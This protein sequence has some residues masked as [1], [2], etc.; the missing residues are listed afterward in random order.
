VLTTFRAR[1]LVPRTCATATASA[2]AA[3]A[4][5]AATCTAATTCRRCGRPARDRL[6]LTS[7]EQAAIVLELLEL[8]LELSE[9][10]L[11]E[12]GG[13]GGGGWQWGDVKSREGK[14]GDVGGREGREGA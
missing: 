11:G 14:L 8:G 1:P 2:S 10:H 5:C 4:T 9:E 13:G 12:S 6:L 7:L 3:T